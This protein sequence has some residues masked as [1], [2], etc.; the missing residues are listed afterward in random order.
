MKQ[1]LKVSGYVAIGVLGVETA[2]AQSKPWNV[3]ATVRGFYDDNY[4]TAPSNPA[5]GQ[6]GKQS[7]YGVELSPGAGF[8]MKRDQTDLALD[9]LYTMRY[10]ENRPNSADHAHQFDLRLDQKFGAERYAATVRDSFVIAQEATLIDPAIAAT[11]LRSNG[12]NIRNFVSAKFQA[13]LSGPLGA[14]FEYQNSFFDYD[15]T[16]PGSRSALLDRMEHL[17]I[18]NLRYQVQR[19]TIA[20]LGYQFGVREQTST[21]PLAG[22][23]GSP[24]PNIRDSYSHYGYVGVDHYF[25]DRFSVHPRV[26]VQYTEYP[27]APA[28]V[29][30]NTV[31]PYADVSAMYGYGE[32]SNIQVGVRHTRTQT[33]VAFNVLVPGAGTTLDA[34]TTAIYANWRHEIT[35]KL[36]S[37]ALIQYQRS[38]FHQ[39]AAGSL[40]DQYVIGGLNISY[41]INEFLSAE[42]GYNYDRLHSEIAN[43][44]FTRNRIYLG[45][46]AKY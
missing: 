3:S 1:L 13:D 11:P 17:A 33:D 46:R 2:N 40:T 18:A 20:L 24:L 28:G 30:G 5:P 15:E 37:T 41:A 44:S 29:S 6:A 26:G 21:D 10:F 14:E 43:R 22:I 4:A 42:A 32:N 12:N 27:N 31:N 38:S 19:T 45:V 23:P 8:A 7:S 36:A 35:A 16:G 34:E 39:G 9:Y 25:T